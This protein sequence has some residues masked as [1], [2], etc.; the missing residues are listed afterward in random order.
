MS[1]D[2]AFTDGEISNYENEYDRI[3]LEGMTAN[4]KTSG[5]YAKQEEK[6]LLNRLEKYKENHLLFLHDF[7]VG[8]SN[9]MS[10]ST[11]FYYPHKVIK[12]A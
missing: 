11:A 3:L 7:Q 12:V 8:F 2:S 6:A 9:N 5:K 1:S 10:L 4:K